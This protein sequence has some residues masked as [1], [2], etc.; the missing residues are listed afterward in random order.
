MLPLLS[1]AFGCWGYDNREAPLRACCPRGGQDCINAEFKAFD[2][3]TNPYIGLA[4][5]VAAGMQGKLAV[6]VLWHGS[7]GMSRRQRLT[8]T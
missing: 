1:G 5:L 3:S 2:G 7:F 6:A 8:V 4:A